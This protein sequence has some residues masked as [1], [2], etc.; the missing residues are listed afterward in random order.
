L[1]H[2]RAILS[3]GVSMSPELLK[4][5]H[6]S[7]VCLSYLLFVLRGRW[8]LRDS[9]LTR[10]RWVRVVP[11]LVDTILLASA[12]TLAASLGISP[13][14]APWLLA[15]IVALLLYI[16]LGSLAIKRG[17]SHRTRWLAWISAQLVFFYIAAT[18]ISHD[19]IPWHGA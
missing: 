12:V 1:V 8:A 3:I 17:Q 11:H 18:A 9:P 16:G 10:Q 7:S 5:I 2:N 19:P 15:K 14:T 4:I 6:V 13:L